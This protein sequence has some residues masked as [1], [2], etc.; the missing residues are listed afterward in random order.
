MDNEEFIELR[1]KFLLGMV[2]S[3]IIVIP[4]LFLFINRYTGVKSSVYKAYKSNETFVVLITNT[5]KKSECQKIKKILKD[6]DVSYLEYNLDKAKDRDLVIPLFG[7]AEKKIQVPALFYVK[8]G[9]T[10]MYTLE[11][12][13]E[14]KVSS[15][16]SSTKQIK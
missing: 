9:K 10:V 2:V 4:F 16:I 7:I 5:E 8:D 3:L 1:N 13:G 11:V 6:S 12:T 14:E 15:F